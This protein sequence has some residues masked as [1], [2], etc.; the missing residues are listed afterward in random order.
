[1]KKIVFLELV[2]FVVFCNVGFSEESFAH[3]PIRPVRK[4]E[5]ITV[6]VGQKQGD[7][8][9]DDDKAIQAAV[10]YVN[11]F[12]GG[13][14][15]ILPGT[16][17]MYNS[18]FMHPNITI[19]GSGND[20]ILKKSAS[21]ST[22]LMQSTDWYEYAVKV[23]DPNIFR[24]GGAI[25][26]ENDKDRLI[27]TV[28]KIDG[29]VIYMD[30][31]TK[32]DFW[33]GTT[34]HAKTVFSIITAPQNTNDVK[35]KNIVLDGN[36]AQSEKVDGNYAAAVFAQN[37]NRWKFE[38][39]TSQNYNGDG[40]SYQVC[41]DFVFENCK[42]LNNS[43]RGFHPGSGSRRPIWKNCSASG[44]HVGLYFCWGVNDGLAE[45]CDFSENNYGST[46]GHRDTDNVIR[47]CTFRNNKNAGIRFR[48]QEEFR[49][50]HRIT[51]QDCYIADNAYG[52]ILEGAISGTVIKNN[53]FESTG[54]DKQKVA[55]KINKGVKDTCIQDNI[56]KNCPIEIEDLR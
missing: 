46:I 27:A 12:G 19:C 20:C 43:Y 3:S 50:A 29:N 56:F 31:Q 39:V 34:P 10:E 33:L 22:P 41:N 16:Y 23:K 47:G 36:R 7:F 48:K 5:T 35:I 21:E 44:N 18:I 13:T 9:G 55:I 17:T 14:V 8:V 1:M 2:L 38:N 32:S 52:V 24:V 53:T 42:A 37:C 26:L 30:R 25:M 54:K 51:I 40:Y 6:T 4:L 49:S 11:R 45:N 15:K 28:T